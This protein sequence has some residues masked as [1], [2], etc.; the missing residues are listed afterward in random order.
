MVSG[1]PELQQTMNGCLG[2]E[3]SA[4]FFLELLF[5]LILQNRDRIGQFWPDVR[6]HIE[7]IVTASLPHRSRSMLVERAVV[8]LLRLSIR[9]LRRDDLASEVLSSLN[10]LLNMSPQTLNHVCV[11]ISYGVHELLKTNAANI[12]SSKDWYTLFTLIEVSFLPPLPCLSH[13]FPNFLSYLSFFLYISTPLPL[14]SLPLYIS[15]PPP[16]CRSRSESP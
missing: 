15:Q 7:G 12:H 16:G 13:S 1:C 10:I 5:R 2:D 8:G 11:H 4:V 3:D 9:L 14:P 6:D